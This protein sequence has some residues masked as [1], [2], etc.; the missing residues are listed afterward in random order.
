MSNIE[1]VDLSGITRLTLDE[2]E[3]KPFLLD[4]GKYKGQTI[5]QV[6]E[7][8]F[9]YCKWL[10]N[11]PSTSNTIKIYIRE[12]VNVNDYTMNWGK[13]KNKTVSWIKE[14]DSKYIE[15]LLKNE[16]VTTKCSKLVEALKN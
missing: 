13:Y 9:S 12:N 10:L 3:Q 6:A 15:W 14:N 1:Q 11:Q 4:F 7:K 5:Q 2:V 16:Y 8:D